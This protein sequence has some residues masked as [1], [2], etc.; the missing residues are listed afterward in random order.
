MPGKKVLIIDDDKAIQTALHALLS[1]VGHQTVSALDAMQGV[2]MARQSPPDLI[3]LDINMPAGGGLSVIQ[4]LRTLSGTMQV[5][6]LIYTAVPLD[7]IR[8]KIPE[9]QDVAFLQKPASL[10]DI[11]DVLALMLPDPGLDRP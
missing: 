7:E 5:P 2:M 4:R 6:I 3:V 9:A 1:G 8:A 11:K 10:Q